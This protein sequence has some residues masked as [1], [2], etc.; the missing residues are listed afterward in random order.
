M[1]AVYTYETANDIVID[2]ITVER[3]YTDGVHT[4]YRITAK[5][6]YV[7]HDPQLDSTCE[8]PET[9][10]TVTEQYYYRQAGIA[11]RNSPD[12]W[13]WEAILENTVDENC[14]FGG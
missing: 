8:D 14:I 7:L 4:A 12:T 6:G 3:K 2:N 13:T 5:N 9:G 10:E 1:M 11:L